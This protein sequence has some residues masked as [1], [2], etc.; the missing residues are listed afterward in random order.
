[1][2]LAMND[3]RGKADAAIVSKILKEKIRELPE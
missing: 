1:M 2:G 3:L